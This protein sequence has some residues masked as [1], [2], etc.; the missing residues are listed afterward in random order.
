M[1]RSLPLGKMAKVEK[2][3]VD[4]SCLDQAASEV[5]PPELS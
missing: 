5:L 3:M 1:L 4:R 2:E